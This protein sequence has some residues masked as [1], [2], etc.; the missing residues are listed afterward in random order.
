MGLTAF[1]GCLLLSLG[2]AGV[3][4]WAVVARRPFLVLVCVARCGCSGRCQRHCMLTQ[5]PPR[6]AAAYLFTLLLAALPW[7]ANAHGAAAPR[8]APR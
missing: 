5:R 4:F 2:P 7:G 8:R 6:S 1:A 3:L